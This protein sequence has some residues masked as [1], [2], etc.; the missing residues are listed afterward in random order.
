VNADGSASALPRRIG[1]TDVRRGCGRRGRGELGPPAAHRR[2]LRVGEAF[3]LHQAEDGDGER[4]DLGAGERPRGVPAVA[5]GDGPRDDDKGPPGAD[6]LPDL[7]D[8][9]PPERLREY[10]ERVHLDHQVEALPPIRR[11]RHKI[12]YHIPNGRAR[13]APP[14]CL[15]RA[16]C[17]VKGNGVEPERRYVLGI[18]TE[19]A[20]D[21]QGAASLASQP[22]VAGPLGKQPARRAPPRHLRPAR[23]GFRVEALEPADWI[24]P[25]ERICGQ[26][27]RMLVWFWPV[28]Q[29]RRT[30]SGP[31]DR[32]TISPSA[33][34]PWRSGARDNLVLRRSEGDPRQ[35]GVTVMMVSGEERQQRG[36]SCLLQ[37]IGSVGDGGHGKAARA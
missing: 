34:R 32:G 12:G 16:C 7:G 31:C 20:A 35:P 17:H 30:A 28:H 11:R 1:G 18:V 6:H 24:A 21:D 22:P 2:F 9:L 3:D 26:A 5:V 13:E 19:A 10:L 27:P 4:L 8:G 29:A 15:D 14:G 33:R 37:V 23:A 25:G 36:H